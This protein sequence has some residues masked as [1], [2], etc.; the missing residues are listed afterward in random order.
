MIG[1][2]NNQGAYFID[3]LQNQI[4]ALGTEDE[5][6]QSEIGTLSSL[7]T[8]AKTNLVSAVNE[9]K[10]SADTAIANTGSLSDLTT[11]AKTNVV[12]AVNEINAKIT[13][14]GTVGG[15]KQVTIT[16]T[17]DSFICL[18]L[19]GMSTATTVKCAYSV[20]IPA[21]G[22]AVYDA[23]YTAGSN[24]S[25]AVDSSNITIKNNSAST[26]LYMYAIVIKSGTYT[27]AITDIP[28]E[29]EET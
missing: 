18:L 12:S 2:E 24:I 1:W 8:T 17:G 27:S 11:S 15:K 10:G 4:N 25:V 9:V 5:T 28:V 19:F 23:I 21:S 7:T 3:K 16:N 13:S 20:I 26:N 22:N 6:L 29:P 14:I